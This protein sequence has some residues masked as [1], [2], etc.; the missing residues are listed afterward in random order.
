[1]IKIDNYN[2]VFASLPVF[3][4]PNTSSTPSPYPAQRDQ[5]MIPFILETVTVPCAVLPEIP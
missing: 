5:P 4:I 3:G 1:M 2:R